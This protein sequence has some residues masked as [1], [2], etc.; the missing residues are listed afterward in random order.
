MHPIVTPGETLLGKYRVERV[1]GQG[2][3]GMVVAARHEGL[4][5]LLAIKLMLGPEGE[6]RAQQARDRFL[7]EARNA[8]RL[9]SEHVAK[10]YDVGQLGDGRPYM[11]MEYLEG[12]DLAEVIERRGPLAVTE[13]A[14]LVLQACDALI[15]AHGLG[16]V[17]RD[18]K[19]SNMFLTRR[20]NGKLCLK[21]LDFGISKR[22]AEESQSLTASGAL[23]GSPLY[24]S[25][26]QVSDAKAVGPRSDIWAMGVV[27]YQ[28]TTGRVPFQGEWIGQVVHAIMLHEPTLP[29]Q[30]RPELPGELDVIVGRC[31]RKNPEE[32]YATMGEFAAALRSLL[33]VNSMLTPLTDLLGEGAVSAEL[34]AAPTAPA[35]EESTQQAPPDE[36]RPAA[37]VETL[38][39]V[40]EKL[41]EL[42][43]AI[44]TTSVEPPSKVSVAP[45]AFAP[46]RASEG[47]AS[48]QS[49]LSRTMPEVAP[50]PPRRASPPWVAVAVGCAALVGIGLYVFQ[51]KPPLPAPSGAGVEPESGTTSLPLAASSLPPP[52]PLE[53]PS[54]GA[55]AVPAASVT[56]PPAAPPPEPTSAPRAATTSTSST[57]AKATSAPSATVPPAPSAPTT[58]PTGKS[59]EGLF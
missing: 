50:A 6:G 2:G 18:L 41:A 36:A 25:P 5:E 24:M 51:G 49:P 44:R 30:I 1:L 16:I 47:S 43:P 34:A 45:E 20:P 40:P 55:R 37:S 57:R 28:L 54:P 9:K 58:K 59:H 27:L 32:R 26:E 15:E 46:A 21:L 35:F 39:E 14:G 12:R 48:T 3:M 31:L 56:A 11:V 53:A 42:L 22:M 4:G 52:A 29:S 23:L 38:S 33:R 19:P 13:A 8:A 7:R 17:H 10:V